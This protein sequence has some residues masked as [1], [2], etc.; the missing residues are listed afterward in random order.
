MVE[1]RLPGRAGHVPGGGEDVSHPHVLRRRPGPGRSSAT[2]P[3]AGEAVEDSAA[4]GFVDN[5]DVAG[6]RLHR[7]SPRHAD[8][9]VTS[10]RRLGAVP[11]PR[12]A[13]CPRHRPTTATVAAGRRLGRLL[14]HIAAWLKPRG[15]RFLRRS[16]SELAG[17][18]GR[19]TASGSPG[20]HRRGEGGLP[21]CGVTSPT[22]SGRPGGCRGPRSRTSAIL[23]PDRGPSLPVSRQSASRWTCRSTSVASGAQPA[24]E[25]RQVAHRGPGPLGGM[26]DTSLSQVDGPPHAPAGS[27]GDQA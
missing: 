26:A 25:R 7:S 12:Q 11:G 3:A 2:V 15:R 18:Q 4:W 5:G 19:P 16:V 6:R 9:G 13:R 21:R 20:W 24:A 14:V 10:M 1:G 8:R 27:Q 23:A 17:G 22:D